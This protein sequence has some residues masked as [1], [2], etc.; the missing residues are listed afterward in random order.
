M[1][2]DDILIPKYLSGLVKK[3]KGDKGDPYAKYQYLALR[4]VQIGWVLTVK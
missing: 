4:N 1:G 3:R 2:I